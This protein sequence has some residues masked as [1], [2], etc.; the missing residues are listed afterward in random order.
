MKC[1]P[2]W[3]KKKACWLWIAVDRLGHRFLNV[4]V[5]SRDTDTGQCLWEG[6][7]HHDIGHIMTDYWQ[8]YE[9]FLPTELHTQSKAETFTVEGYNSLFRHFLTRLRRK[10]CVTLSVCCV[11]LFCHSFDA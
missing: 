7:A 10:S 8:P 2:C 9:L 5:G 6:V 3:L 1:I 11:T 4:I